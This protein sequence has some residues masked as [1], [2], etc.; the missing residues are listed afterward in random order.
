LL[1][2]PAQLR[3]VEIE[4]FAAISG[5]IR[6]FYVLHPTQMICLVISA[7]SSYRM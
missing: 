7:D 6:F 4:R 1:G 2:K 5:K 3:G